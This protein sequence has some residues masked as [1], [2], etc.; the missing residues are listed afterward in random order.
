MS[1][2]YLKI[3]KN[4]NEIEFST[5]DENLFN[6]K[7]EEFLKGFRTFS[8][9]NQTQ[10]VPSEEQ[11]TE[12]LCDFVDI[13]ES[14]QTLNQ[15]QNNE[16]NTN[17]LTMEFEQILESAQNTPTINFTEPENSNEEFNSFV[18]SQN[19]QNEMDYL[20]F[21]AMYFLKYLQKQNFTLKQINSKLV[22]TKNVAISHRII[23]EAI[24]QGFIQEVPDL[25]ETSVT[26]EY[27]LTQKGEFEYRI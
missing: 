26:K 8:V 2:F 15:L 14:S 11:E 3:R 1:N 25:T 6:E 10:N 7:V 16:N 9:E 20:I 24:G 5:D 22:P 4:D 12:T 18:T 19:P 17:N 21:S 27:S 13:G 23:N